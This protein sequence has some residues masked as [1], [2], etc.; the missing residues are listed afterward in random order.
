[1]I[2]D[3]IG[4]YQPPNFDAQKEF[5]IA[6]N[7]DVFYGFPTSPGVARGKA[8]ILSLTEGNPVVVADE[9]IITSMTRPELGA[10]LDVALA[11]VTDEGGRL[12]HAA[13]VSREKKKP[14]VTGLGDV[15]KVLRSGMLIE[16]DGTAGTVT[17]LD[18]SY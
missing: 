11:Y 16:V 2:D 5:N 3:T 6:K 8:R 4:F 7:G 18:G 14:C 9:I 12:C 17:V 1:M 15:T 13:I 10:A